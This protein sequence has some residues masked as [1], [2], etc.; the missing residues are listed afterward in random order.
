MTE[1]IKQSDSPEP[2]THVIG[3]DDARYRIER[4]RYEKAKAWHYGW[5]K[6]LHAAASAIGSISE[7]RIDPCNTDMQKAIGEAINKINSLHCNQAPEP[8]D[9]VCFGEDDEQFVRDAIRSAYDQ[10]YNHARNA[11]SAPGDSALGY[12]GRDISDEIAMDVL[13]RMRRLSSLETIE[14]ISND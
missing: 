9:L 5:R 14:A 4:M 12:R 8:Q 6:A 13:A 7:A 2:E 1:N 3:D 11:K 10:G